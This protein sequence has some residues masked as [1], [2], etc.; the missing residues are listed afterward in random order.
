MTTSGEAKHVR[1]TKA[2]L[3]ALDMM[4]A[5]GSMYP[6]KA[7]GHPNVFD[8]LVRRGMATRINTS[9]PFKITPSGLTALSNNEGN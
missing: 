5:I 7:A 8:A 4:R 2:Q 9:G 3:K 6:C 1:L